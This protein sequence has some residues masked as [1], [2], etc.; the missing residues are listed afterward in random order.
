[1]K[2]YITPEIELFQ[3]LTEDVLAPSGTSVTGNSET[4]PI[5]FKVKSAFD[6]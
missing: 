2:E 4:L 3:F 1:M 6:I 5:F